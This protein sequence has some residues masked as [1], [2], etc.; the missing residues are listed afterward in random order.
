MD[1]KAI[2]GSAIKLSAKPTIKHI[3]EIFS[4]FFKKL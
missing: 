4:A 2:T 3:H 1:L